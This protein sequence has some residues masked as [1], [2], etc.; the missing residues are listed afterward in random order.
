M[1]YR[2]ECYQIVGACFEVYNAKGCGFLESVYQ[3]C[4]EI[5]FRHRGIPFVPQPELALSYRGI[6]LRQSFRADF[7]CFGAVIVELKAVAGLC[8]Q[9]QSQVLN[10]LHATGHRLGLLVNFGGHPDLEYKR[11]VLTGERSISNGGQPQNPIRADSRD[12]RATPR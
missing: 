8:D 2:E 5:E 3:E 10:Y 7:L 6:A 1:I 12:P 4:L 9:H 11:I